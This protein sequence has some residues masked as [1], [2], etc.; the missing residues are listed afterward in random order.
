MDEK[1]IENLTRNGIKKALELQK[2]RKALD[3]EALLQQCLKIWDEKHE[4]TLQAISFFYMGEERPDLGELYLKKCIKYF[5]ENL[6]AKHLLAACYRM[7]GQQETGINYL[8]EVE[9]QFPDDLVT[10]S[11]LCMFYKDF[12]KHN[13]A[14]EILTKVLEKDT[15]NAPIMNNLAIVYGE[16]GNTTKAE[17]LLKESLSIDPNNPRTI[18]NLFN[19]LASQNKY[20]EAWKLHDCRF[21]NDKQ[22]SWVFE[23]KLPILSSLEE[24]E[25]KRILVFCEQ[26]IGDNVMFSR[27]LPELQKK[28]DFTVCVD[29]IRD[30]W[31][32]ALGYKTFNKNKDP[33]VG[34]FDALIGIQSLPRILNLGYIPEPISPIILPKKNLIKKIGLCWSGNGLAACDV[35]RSIHFEL[36]KEYLPE[37]YEYFSFVQ[38]HEPR[39]HPDTK[40]MYDYSKGFDP[41]KIKCFSKEMENITSTMNLLK[42]MDLLITVDTFIAHLS[43]SMNIQTWIINRINTDWRWGN[44]GSRT[45]WYKS[46]RIFRQKEF[47]NWT[48][49]LEEIKEALEK[50]LFN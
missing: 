34:N 37:K 45:L 1:E 8:L 3:A 42:D 33:I 46:A 50:S 32:S 49:P 6:Q 22:L 10:K 30:S 28:I 2:E 19:C 26:G 24:V 40:R 7:Q 9:K 27:Y 36:L 35:W 11:N 41:N 14:I 44:E 17:S 43:A 29:D 23:T 47:G 5:P 4:K 48:H 12:G 25:N 31:F 18:A 21:I 39:M 16:L 13:K 20:E 38:H 15:T